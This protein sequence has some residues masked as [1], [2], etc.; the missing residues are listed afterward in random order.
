MNSVQESQQ[1]LNTA[2]DFRASQIGDV[3][4]PQHEQ[5]QSDQ[6]EIGL[7]EDYNFSARNPEGISDIDDMHPINRQ[8]TVYK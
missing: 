6:A 5:D 7:E 3:I 8:K 2:S 4:N 1:L